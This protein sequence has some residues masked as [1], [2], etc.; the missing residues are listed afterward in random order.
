MMESKKANCYESVA[1]IGS[2]LEH[3]NQVT[4]LHEDILAKS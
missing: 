3:E 2:L 4:C 1:T